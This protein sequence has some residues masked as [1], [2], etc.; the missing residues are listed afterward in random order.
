M[1]FAERGTVAAHPSNEGV[2]LSVSFKQRMGRLVACGVLA[3]VAV[4]SAATVAQPRPSEARADIVYNYCGTLVPA[5]SQCT[6]TRNGL[7]LQGNRATYPG[8]GSVSVC[9][10][11]ERGSDGALLSR[12]CA[13]TTVASDGDLPNGPSN[14]AI[15]GNNDNGQHTVNGR[16][17]TR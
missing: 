17:V 1:G 12:R 10:R 3:G 4:T 11:V 5:F 13:I 16:A 15:V 9:E 2:A 14:N 6:D 8:S 7:A